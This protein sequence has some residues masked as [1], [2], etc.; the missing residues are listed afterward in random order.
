MPTLLKISWEQQGQ[1]HNRLETNPVPPAF[2]PQCASG[3]LHLIASHMETGRWIPNRAL[4]W[5]SNIK[6]SIYYRSISIWH[7]ENKSESVRYKLFFVLYLVFLRSGTAFSQFCWST[8]RRQQQALQHGCWEFGFLESYQLCCTRQQRR[9]EA[10]CC[11]SILFST[12]DKGRR[13]C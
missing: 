5:K 10:I 2:S 13:V 1:H 6:P 11:S 7:T 3:A 8:G 12:S 9:K 4:L